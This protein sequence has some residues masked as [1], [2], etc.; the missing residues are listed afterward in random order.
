MTRD[1][2][3]P[4]RAARRQLP[5]VLRRTPVPPLA[6]VIGIVLATFLASTAVLGGSP[7]RVATSCALALLG[8][9]VAALIALAWGTLRS[10]VCTLTGLVVA[11][12]LV[13]SHPADS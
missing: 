5:I 10:L 7:D 11:A 9:L 8:G 4:E 12:S 6:G 3:R 13:A 1:R 2:A